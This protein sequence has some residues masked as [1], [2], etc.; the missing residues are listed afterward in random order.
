MRM[1]RRA[2]LAVVPSLWILLA[3]PSVDAAPFRGD[4]RYFPQPD[5][6]NVEVRL[7]GT[8]F[9]MRAESP[10]GYALIFGVHRNYF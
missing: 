6:T 9:Y 7:F 4:S 10:D 5:G 1:L 8:E 3:L 2:L